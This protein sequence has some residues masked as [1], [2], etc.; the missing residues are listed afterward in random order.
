MRHTKRQTDE[1]EA[2]QILDACPVVQLAWVDADGR[3]D[4]RSLHA[5]RLGRAVYI[6]GAPAGAKTGAVERWVTISGEEIVARIP[7]HFIEPERACPA[8]TYY[9]SVH[10]RGRLTIERDPDQR[11]SALEAL[12][13]ALQPEG[14]YRPITADDPL[15]AKTLAG[16]LVGRVDIVE[17]VGRRK[18]GQTSPA[19]VPRVLAGLWRRG[20]PGDLRA[21]ERIRRVNP[22]AALPLVLGDPLPG[23]SL[24]PWRDP[25]DRAPAMAID[26]KSVV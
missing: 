14:G 17:I 8:T 13:Q 3:P 20:G 26:R 21:F 1:A 25:A 23:V 24:H 6:H 15:Y 9:R 22:R 5:A 16:L 18:M 2:L 7:S 11:A 10:V 4:I 12:M 19:R